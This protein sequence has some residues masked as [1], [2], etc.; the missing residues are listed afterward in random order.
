MAIVDG[1]LCT[2]TCVTALG[3]ELIAGLCLCRRLDA[4]P[5]SPP[6]RRG[7]CAMQSIP[8]KEGEP[9]RDTQLIFVEG[10]PRSGK[11]T[12]AVWLAARLHSER[13]TVNLL[14]EHQPEHSLNVGST[15][16][17]SRDTTGEAFFQRYTSASFVHESLQRWH[18]FVRTALQTEAISVLDSYPFQNTVR[19]LLQLH[20]T[21]DCM[22]EYAGH[23]EALVMPLR[24]VLIYFNHRDLRQVFHHLSTI[25]AQRGKAWTDYVV[26]L[27]THCPYAR[28]K[29]L[30]GFSGA[31]A[32]I[33]D[34]KLLTDTLLRHSR[35]PRLVLEDC[36]GGWEGCYQQIEAFL[37]LTSQATSGAWT[38]TDA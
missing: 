4:G 2:V 38:V 29:H 7:H 30:E 8:D 18:A 23:V 36:A 9:M 14:L 34:Y 32:V 25:S 11:T 27:I 13:L 15:L 22:K 17:P 20:T 33:R 21:P 12:T 5:R 37:G 28:A 26:E 24:P 19:V 35:V 31:L 10:L 3:C 16:H 6:C 1:F